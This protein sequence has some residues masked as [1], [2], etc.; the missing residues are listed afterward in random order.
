MNLVSAVLLQVDS[1]LSADGGVLHARSDH[2]ADPVAQ[3]RASAWREV[4]S[5][6]ESA[7]SSPPCRTA[8]SLGRSRRTH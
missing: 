4:T 3:R 5:S 2:I 8:S 7:C 1:V 6:W